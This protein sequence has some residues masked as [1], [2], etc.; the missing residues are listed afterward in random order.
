VDVTRGAGVVV[1][2]VDTGIDDGHPDLAAN[3]WTNPGELAGNGVDDDGN[4]F[5]DDVRGWDFADGDADPHDDNL[6]GTHV[7][8]TVAAVGGN[9]AGIVGVAHESRVMAVRGLGTFGSGSVSELTEAILYAVDNGADVVNASW[10]GGGS[11]QTIADAIAVAH[12]AGVVFVAAAGNEADDTISFFPASDPN[13]ITVAAFTHADVRAP[14]SNFGVK[15]DVGAPGGGDEP[16]PTKDPWYSILSLLAGG[17]HSANQPSGSWVLESGGASYLRIAGTSMAAPHVAGTAALVLAVHPGFGVEQVRQVL[18]TTADDLPPAGPDTDSGYGLVN[19]AAAVL[20]PE[21]LVAHIASPASGSL[22]GPTGVE[23]VGSA[24][25]PGFVSYTVDYRPLDDPGGWTP[26][27]GPVGIPVAATGAPRPGSMRA[28]SR[29]P[30]STR[31]SATSRR[32]SRASTRRRS[33]SSRT[34]SSRV[35]STR[36]GPSASRSATSTATVSRS[37]SA[38]WSAR[39]AASASTPASRTP[40]GP[41]RAGRSRCSMR[42]ARRSG[43]SRS[44]F[45]SSSP[46]RASRASS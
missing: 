9:G 31:S 12:A 4:G 20:A 19:A 33:R 11:S 2:I 27:A 30:T 13:A 18:R 5:V 34:A 40:R 43:A 45:P 25:G 15:L 24:G 23:V 39:A 7:A 3:V 6:H 29:S 1:A 36:T 38:A 42:T 21:P 35:R 32:G 44:R 14:F 10:G 28:C 41:R 46:S 8:G 22:V 37:S 26:I 17:L 16:P